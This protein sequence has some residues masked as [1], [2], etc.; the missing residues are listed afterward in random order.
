MAR[1]TTIKGSNRL[2]QAYL[3][4]DKDPAIDEFR[5]VAQDH[6]G[7]RNLA[8]SDYAD[9]E[10]NGGPVAGTIKQW[11]EGKTRRPQNC[12]LEAAGRAL[13]LRRVWVKNR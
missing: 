1:R 7:K 4:R 3:F 9:I 10:E 13:G 2:Y 12:T 6:Y 8:G 5:T 11:L